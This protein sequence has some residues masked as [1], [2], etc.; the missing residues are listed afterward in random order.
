MDQVP[1]AARVLGAADLPDDD[2]RLPRLPQELVQPAALP[3]GLM[4]VEQ[5]GGELYL[6]GTDSPVAKP[7]PGVWGADG[8]LSPDGATFATTIQDELGT[9][10]ALIDCATGAVTLVAGRFAHASRAP[11]WAAG[12]RRLLID[13]P[14]D[15]CVFSC[16]LSARVLR[17]RPILRK[18][19]AV[20]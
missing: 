11:V 8:S 17:L 18:R 4:M 16:N 9:S 15:H 6:A 14:L 3:L 10:V 20:L 7:F 13:A 12:G 1:Q 2:V 5:H 19:G